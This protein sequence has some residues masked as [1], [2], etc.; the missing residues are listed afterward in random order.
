VQDLTPRSSAAPGATRCCNARPDT[1]LVSLAQ[2]IAPGSKLLQA[3][4]LAG[5][6]SAQVTAFELRNADGSTE[7]LVVRRHGARD[8]A[9]D[10]EIAAHEFRVLQVVREAGVCAP[11]PRYLDAAGEFY[12]TPCIVL[13]YVDAER[14]AAPADDERFVDELANA[15]AEIHRVDLRKLSFLRRLEQAGAPV[16]LHGDFWPGNALWREGALVAIVDWEDAAIG[17]PLADVANARLELLWAR[18]HGAMDAFT[19]RY[20]AR[21]GV[22]LAHLPHWDLWADRRL[23]P[24]I[25]EWRLDDAAQREMRAKRDAFVA[26]ARD[27]S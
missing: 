8:L 9:R 24:R 13:E 3:W 20:A 26:Q 25:R 19:K 18:G 15:L 21:T 11:A 6:V 17:D 12:G 27:A 5:G 2:E 23:T 1:T 16:L 14:D 22:D 10:P 7:R 4:P